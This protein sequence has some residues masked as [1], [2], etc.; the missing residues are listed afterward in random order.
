MDMPTNRRTFLLLTATAAALPAQEEK[1]IRVAV[2]ATGHRSWIHLAVLRALPAFEIVALVDPTQENLDH[3]ATLAGGRPA[4]YADY[5]KM[6]AERKDLDAA[7]VLTPNF[8]HAEAAVAALSAGLDVLCEKPMATTVEDANRMIAAAETNGRILQIGQQNRFNPLYVK[9]QQLVRAGEIGVV[10]YVAGNIF[11]GDWYAQSWRYTDSRTHTATNWRFLTHTAGSSLMEDGIHEIDV[12]HGMIG[13]RVTRVYASGGN[14]VYKD[15]ETIDHAGIVIDYEN[16]V[17]FTFNFCLFGQNSGPAARQMVVAGTKG[18]MQTG[19]RD[20]ILIGKQGGPGLQT[21]EP[22]GASPS[23]VTAATGPAGVEAATYR[24]YLAFAHSVRTREKP[25]VSGQVGKEAI[26]I[27]L[28]A[29]KSLRERRP[30]AWN[31]LPA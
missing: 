22:G 31:D 29:E 6:L 17:K 20:T 21:V 16:G 18:V 30:L 28:L 10:E 11:R 27:S 3:G 13:A 19:G 24:E 8:L 12:L 7:I 9:M 4:L 26:K 5:R 2:I 25:L 23:P 14:N 15:R 1:K